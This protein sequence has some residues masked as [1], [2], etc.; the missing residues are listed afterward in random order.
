MLTHLGFA[1]FRRECFRKTEQKTRDLLARM[2][3]LTDNKLHT[4][5]LT[6]SVTSKFIHF[7][8]D[9][10]SLSHFQQLDR[11]IQDAFLDRAIPRWRDSATTSQEDFRC[12]AQQAQSDQQHA[13]FGIGGLAD[14]FGAHYYVTILN[15]LRDFN[16]T[17]DGRFLC[18]RTEARRKRLNG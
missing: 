7:L 16:D 10:T 17:A 8:P 12:M 2:R 3:P 6:H 4:L 14:S 1:D 13:G 18:S 11:H 15:C 9:D 5:M